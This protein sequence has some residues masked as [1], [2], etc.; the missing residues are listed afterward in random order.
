[1]AMRHVLKALVVMS[2]VCTQGVWA[3][4][5]SDS[6]CA[7]GEVCVWSPCPA[8]DCSPG[9]SCPEPAC[10]ETGTCEQ[11]E[12]DVYWG[13][14]CETTADCPMGFTCEESGLACET[15]GCGCACPPCE[16]GGECPPCECDCPEPP[17]C[18]ESVIKVCAFSPQ[19]C[20][21]DA[22]CESGFEC[23]AEEVCY[24]SS[25]ACS[26]TDCVCAECPPGETCPPC[27]CPEPEPCSCPDEPEETCETVGN[28]CVPKQVACDSASDCPADWDCAPIGGGDTT[29]CGCASCPPG[30]TCPPCECPEPEP[31]E[32]ASYC[33]PGGWGALLDGG[34][35]TGGESTPTRGESPAQNFAEDVVAAD[36]T[37]SASDAADCACSSVTASHP[38]GKGLAWSLLAVFGFAFWRRRR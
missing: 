24:G 18:D 38:S 4:C 13:D 12:S 21:S 23:A 20:S 5:S 37:G 30:E 17:P 22:D 35:S 7:S 34:V 9:S 1:M 25:C 10:P 36:D 8:I 2:L 29:T 16:P 33:L 15:Y 14:T 27:E 26:G 3:E 11:A 19:A 6:D 32:T 28:Y 31:T